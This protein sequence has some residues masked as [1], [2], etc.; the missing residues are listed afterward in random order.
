MDP[1]IHTNKEKFLDILREGEITL[2]G[3]FV[4]GYNYTF[5]I[6]VGDK[7]FSQKAVYKP[8]KGQQPIWDFPDYNL[9][10]REVAA[11]LVSDSLGWDQVPA[12]VLRKTGPLGPGSIQLYVDHDPNQHYFTFN[13]DTRSKLHS[14]ALFDF[15]INNADRKGGH[16]LLDSSKKIWLIDHGLCFHEEDKIRTVIWDFVEQPIPKNLLADLEQF[17]QA[18]ETP[19]TVLKS[20]SRLINKPEMSSLRSRC[21]QLIAS[22][23]FPHPPSDRRYFPYPPV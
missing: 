18:L 8:D 9:S 15:L 7:D 10:R 16:I 23:I 13:E 6:E 14:T 20:L 1:S 3:Q 21:Q 17:E 5:L 2:Q 22:P 11:Y 19:G 4:L 12:T